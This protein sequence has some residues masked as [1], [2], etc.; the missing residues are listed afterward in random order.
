MKQ[1]VILAVRSA[2][3]ASAIHRRCSKVITTLLLGGASQADRL[4]AV[5]WPLSIVQERHSLFRPQVLWMWTGS[6]WLGTRSAAQALGTSAPPTPA[7][8]VQSP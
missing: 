2:S 1:A 7:S 4:L 6:R 5:R 8:S 3:L